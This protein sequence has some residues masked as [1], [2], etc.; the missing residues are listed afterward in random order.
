MFEF[1]FDVPDMIN[2]SFQMIAAPFISLSIVKLYKEKKVRGISYLHVAF[3]TCWGFW[4][5]FYYPYLGQWS[6]FV[7]GIVI[8]MV[9][10]IWLIQMIY[11]VRLERKEIKC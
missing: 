6:S 3:F 1:C 10:L 7:G 4:N 8:V 9:N 5:L 11:Y 2:G